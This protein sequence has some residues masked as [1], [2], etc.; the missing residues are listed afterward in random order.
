M[1]LF[2]TQAACWMVLV[3]CC[4][5]AIWHVGRCEAQGFLRW[6]TQKKKIKTLPYLFPICLFIHW[7]ALSNRPIWEHLD[8]TWLITQQAKAW[9]KP[10]I[11]CL[12]DAFSSLICCHR[13]SGNACQMTYFCPSR[14]DWTFSKAQLTED[15]RREPIGSGVATTLF[16]CAN[17]RGRAVS[18]EPRGDDRSSTSRQFE[19]LPNGDE[20]FLKTPATTCTTDGFSLRLLFYTSPSR[21]SDPAVR[22]LCSWKFVWR[23]VNLPSS[24]RRHGG[25]SRLPLPHLLSPVAGSLGAL[26]YCVFSFLSFLKTKKQTWRYNDE[27][28]TFCRCVCLCLA[29]MG[30]KQ[31]GER[32]E[33]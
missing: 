4:S 14:S 19:R 29:K 23:T 1:Y 15:P 5:L 18:V 13:V 24:L 32:C 22:R 30:R 21:C 3:Q 7:S 2:F 8:W 12:I 27:G 11:K 20:C 17:V 33:T 26:G 16:C 10:S 28:Y 25:E 31:E 9:I 6:F